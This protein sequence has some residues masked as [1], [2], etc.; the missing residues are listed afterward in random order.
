[1]N[2]QTLGRVAI[3]IWMVLVLVLFFAQFTAEFDTAMDLIRRI[4]PFL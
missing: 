4:L 1:M 2:W 3:V